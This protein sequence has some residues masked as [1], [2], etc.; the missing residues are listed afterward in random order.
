MDYLGKYGTKGFTESLVIPLSDETSDLTTADG[1]YS[2]YLPYAL[3]I[4]K[5][6]LSLNS[7]CAGAD[8]EVDCQRNG[9]TIFDTDRLVVAQGTNISTLQPDFANPTVFA[10]GSKMSFNIE[11]IGSTTAGAG[12]KVM[13]H[14]HRTVDTE[15]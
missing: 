5:M 3:T 13:I 14:G 15:L 9:T 7:T 12:L 6:Y 4:D 8:V 11:Q 1:V 2:F 10:I